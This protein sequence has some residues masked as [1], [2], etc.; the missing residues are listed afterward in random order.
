M[1]FDHL[2]LIIKHIRP[3]VAYLLSLTAWAIK[4]Y[5][6]MC[7]FYSIVKSI[8]TIRIYSSFIYKFVIHQKSDDQEILHSPHQLSQIQGIIRRLV[9][10]YKARQ[11]DQASCSCLLWK[12]N[13]PSVGQSQ[14]VS[15]VK[16]SPNRW[17]DG[18]DGVVPVIDH[19]AWKWCVFDILLI[20]IFL[21]IFY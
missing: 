18:W 20:P 21:M 19:S 17:N 11:K 14:G 6:Q 13:A 9:Y 16:G 1:N 5:M 10:C 8:Y 2:F 4:F 15:L 12:N 3:W 7:L